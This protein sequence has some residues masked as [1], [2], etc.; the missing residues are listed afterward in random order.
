[1]RQLNT[2][3][4]GGITKGIFLL[5]SMLMT[6]SAPALSSPIGFTATT[7]ITVPPGLLNVGVLLDPFTATVTYGATV[8]PTTV[9]YTATINWGD[10]STSTQTFPLVAALSDTTI[11]QL[12]SHQYSAP[13]TYTATITDTVSATFN[14]VTISD[15]S[16]TPEILVV[17]PVAATPLPSALPMFATGLGALGLFSWRKKRKNA[18]IAAT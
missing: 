14:G 16:E 2:T 7:D 12:L 5:T 13:A 8:A 11:L 15:T 18:A 17:S 4:T 1:M 9:N 6:F 10:N 3:N